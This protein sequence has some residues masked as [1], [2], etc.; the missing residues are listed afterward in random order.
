MFFITVFPCIRKLKWNNRK[1][2]RE[3]KSSLVSWDA[4]HSAEAARDKDSQPSQK[5]RFWYEELCRYS[6]L[7]APMSSEY[8]LPWQPPRFLSGVGTRAFLCSCDL[9]WD[10][11]GTALATIS[12]TGVE[13]VVQRGSKLLFF[14]VFPV[15]GAGEGQAAVLTLTPRVALVND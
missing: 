9:W 4:D 13:T 3:A 7:W 10:F 2:M 14:T 5:L 8:Q 1:N 12:S 11:T 6:F 15:Q